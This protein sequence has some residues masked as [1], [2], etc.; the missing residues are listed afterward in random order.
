MYWVID[1]VNNQCTQSYSEE[2]LFILI[3]NDFLN[4]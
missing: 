4:M 3:Q 1:E 2:A